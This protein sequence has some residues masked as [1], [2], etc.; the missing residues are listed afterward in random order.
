MKTAPFVAAAAMLIAAAPHAAADSA[1]ATIDALQSQGY[2]VMEK[3]HIYLMV[4]AMID[5]GH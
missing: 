1:Q 3:C 2:V 4:L 5:D